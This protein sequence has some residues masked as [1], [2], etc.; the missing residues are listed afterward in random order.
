MFKEKQT[1]QKNTAINL[2]SAKFDYKSEKKDNRVQTLKEGIAPSAF[3]RGDS[4]FIIVGN[5]FCRSFY[6][7]GFP[8]YVGVGYL[9]TLY[10]GD[11]DVDVNLALD[12]R[13]YAEIRQELQKKLTITKAK[14]Q[15]EI[16]KGSNKDRDTYENTIASLE[17]QLA[18][19]ASRDE[20]AYETQLFFS[21]YADSKKELER[22]SNLLI[23]E[24]KASDLTIHT[25]ALRQD[26]AWKNIVPYGID[27]IQDKKRNFNT[28]AVV[29]SIPFYIP[30]LYDDYG[31]FIGHN[32]F[33]GSPAL[34]DLYKKGIKNSNLNIFGASGSG[35]STFVKTL[36]MRSSLHGI[37]SVIIDPEGEYNNVT[38]KLHGGIVKFSTNINNA[39]VMNI[40]DVEEEED[41]DPITGV[42]TITLDL[43][44]KYLDVLGF[45]KV[46]YPEMNKED[47]ANLLEVIEELYSRF[48][49]VD[50]D[51]ESL[52]L[53]DDQIVINGKLQNNSYK[54]KVPK[55]GDF[56]DL[57]DVLIRDGSFPTLQTAYNSLQV[58]RSSKAKGMFDTYTPDYLQ[59]LKDLPVINFDISSIESSEIRSLSMY[60]LLSWIWEKFGKKNPHI[61]KR[62][63]VDE[64]WMMMASNIKGSEF[65]SDF[66]E[67]MSRRIRKRNGAL[68]VSSQ[69][70]DDFANSIKGQAIISNAHTTFLLSHEASDKNVLKKAFALDEGVVDNIIEA[71]VGRILLKQGSQLYLIQSYL[72]QNEKITATTNN[73]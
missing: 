56:L 26:K 71:E 12:K 64:A 37:R 13:Q 42:K 49:F 45:F 14:L 61:K 55:I 19:L 73:G 25:F 50:G 8:S 35:K 20:M 60:I 33:T 46:A 47:E 34:L 2:N 1:E 27:Y 58:Y 9:S 31:V 23:Q 57:L 68:V 32:V 53:N 15:E 5:K 44:S 3:Q 22:Q 16:Q 21:L 67:N 39:L 52:Y 17:T 41:L 54:R 7:E 36:I 63:I 43:R 38:K 69:K 28:G 18:E 4:D 72:F 11:Y 10:S 24:L 30:E 40:F 65:T 51:P 29:S 48:G 6:F 62:I 70:V 66:L 59:N